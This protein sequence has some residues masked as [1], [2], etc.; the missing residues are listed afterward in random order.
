MKKKTLAL[1]MTAA[2]AFSAL[3]GCGSTGS[4]PA[5]NEETTTAAEKKETEAVT[6]AASESEKPA[7]R[8]EVRVL[9][10]WSESQVSNWPVHVEEYNADASNPV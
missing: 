2:M 7:E 1:V 4:A 5:T 10:K 8:P 3:T 6:E 9:I